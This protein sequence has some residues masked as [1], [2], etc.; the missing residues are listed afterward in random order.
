MSEHTK[1]THD[2]FISYSTKNKNVA[3]AVVSDFE[4]HGIKCWY[5]PRDILPGEEWVTAITTALDNSRALVLIF[6]D[7]S[8][9][10]RQVMNEIAMA[11][12]AGLTIVP[13][14]LTN[15]QMSSE[16]EYYLT[17]VHWLDAVSKP[18]KTNI[19]AL[20]EYVE[21]I[22]TAPERPS[23]VEGNADRQSVKGDKSFDAGGRSVPSSLVYVLT[24]V[25]I[26][27][28]VVFALMIRIIT[29]REENFSEDATED[30]EVI[31]EDVTDTEQSEGKDPD[32]LYYNPGKD[33]ELV[34]DYASAYAYYQEGIEKGSLFSY[35]GMGDL[36]YDGHGVPM[37]EEKALEYYLLAGG[38]TEGD[39]ETLFYRDKV[40]VD[41]I[42]FINRIGLIYFY[43]EEY[44]KALYFFMIN[45]EE[46]RDVNGIGNVALTYDE[47]GDKDN[48][49]LWYE[50]AI[51][52]GHRDAE[53]YK[54]RV[55]ELQ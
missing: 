27:F 52:A 43:N 20:R 35:L 19:T 17:R 40:G 37:D 11:F 22:L 55:S 32:S 30:A 28:I 25:I 51:E 13:F 53:N 33:K 18:L 47:L 8:N 29:T 54:K 36:Y 41:D 12:N 16:L 9:N 5:A 38:F 21:I 23:G 14:K 49:V 7:E 4:Q 45:A 42:A 3:D 15:E 39:E 44:E 1:G 48:A 2:I 10:S 26:L 46:N 6:T 31:T 24:V 34:G 50:K